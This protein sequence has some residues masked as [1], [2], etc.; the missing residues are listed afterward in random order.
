MML[1]EENGDEHCMTKVTRRHGLQ[2]KVPDFN[3][4]SRISISSGFCK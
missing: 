2:E 4:P 3:T 1:K